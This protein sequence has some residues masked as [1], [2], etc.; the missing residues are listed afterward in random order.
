MNDLAGKKVLFICPHFFGYEREIELE[1]INLGAKVD[2]FNERPLT[3]SIAKILNRLDFKFFLNKKINNYF[4]DILIKAKN[5]NYDFLLVVNPET[6]PVDFLKKLNVACPE[7]HSVLYLWDSIKNKKNS[8]LLV[9]EFKRVVTFDRK[10]ADVNP[11]IE[12]LPLFYTRSYEYK[13]K[14]ENNMSYNAAFIGTAHSDRYLF[15]KK[16]LAQMPCSKDNYSFFYCPSKLLFILKKVFTKE[17]AG[18]SWRNI[19]FKSMATKD[20]ISIL[21]DTDFVIDVEHPNQQGLTMRTIEMLGLQKKLITTNKNIIDYDFYHP[22]NICVV[23]RQNPKINT[24]FLYSDYCTID[25]G[26]RESYALNSW[27]KKL[28]FKN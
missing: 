5:E 3:S 10:D 26:I 25:Q 17:L 12:F 18:I 13:I 2:Y 14:E 11:R 22:N 6:M 27:L 19:S 23:D 28:L 21:H 4:D 8:F 1:L 16:V 9:D 20:I 24:V 7:M 15:V